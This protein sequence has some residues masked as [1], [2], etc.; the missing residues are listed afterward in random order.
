MESNNLKQALAVLKKNGYRIAQTRKEI[1]RLLI[2]SQKELSPQNIH[3]FLTENEYQID[4]VSVYRIIETLYENHL[5]HKTSSGKIIWCSKIHSPSPLTSAH[6]FYYLKCSICSRVN[7]TSDLSLNSN[8]Q[9]LAIKHQFILQESTV[10]IKGICSLCQT[11]K[12]L[13]TRG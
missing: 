7:E 1:I 11:Q 5:I 4:R 9:S 13:E 6:T 3:T 10:E 12:K 8:I 2:Q